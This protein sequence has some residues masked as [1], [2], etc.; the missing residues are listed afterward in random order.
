[1]SQGVPGNVIHLFSI[2]Y[3]DNVLE[4]FKPPLRERRDI[5]PCCCMVNMN[6]KE[7]GQAPFD[8]PALGGLSVRT[9]TCGEK[10]PL[11]SHPL[12]DYNSPSPPH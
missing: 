2:S 4:R 10:Y 11:N 5:D 7:V 12:S 9:D 8:T 1:M 3:L 6:H